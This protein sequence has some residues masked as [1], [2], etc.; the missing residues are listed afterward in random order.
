MEEEQEIEPGMEQPPTKRPKNHAAQHVGNEPPLQ[1]KTLLLP[2][3]PLLRL[4]LLLFLQSSRHCRGAT[5]HENGTSPGR[6]REAIL[7]EV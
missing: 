6:G 2:L 5:L 1:K 7:G 3:P 4:L